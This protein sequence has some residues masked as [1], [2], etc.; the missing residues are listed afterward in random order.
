MFHLVNTSLPL[1]LD[2]AMLFLIKVLQSIL[3]L[4]G[5]LELGA[6]PSLWSR[7]LSNFYF[8]KQIGLLLLQFRLSLYFITIYLVVLILQTNT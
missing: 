4:V 5:F 6:R 7:H 2:L 1:F 8:E 3:D